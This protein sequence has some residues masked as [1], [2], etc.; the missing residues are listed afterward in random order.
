MWTADSR[1]QGFEGVSRHDLGMGELDDKI[2]RLV[3][4]ACESDLGGILL[5][6]QTNFSWLSGGGSNRID[7]SREPGAG[8]LFVAANGRRFVIAND[9][10]MPRLVAEE[11]SQGSWEPIE[12]PWTE[13]QARPDTVVRLAQRA[14][15]GRIGADWP[16]PAAV[17][18]DRP[19]TRARNLLTQPEAERYVRLG[20]D[21][22]RVLGEV[23]R[24]LEPGEDERSI[25]A[26]ADA[27]MA[28]V[29]ARAVV[30]L[31]AADDRIARFRHPV[32]GGL[33][34]QRLVMVVVGARRHGLTVSLSRIVS[35]GRV[36]APLRS[37][38]EANARVFA[39]LLE[40]TQPGASGRDL[41]KVAQ[42]AYA[43][44]GFPGE[45]KRHHQGGATGYR[46]RE[47]IA[48]PASEEKV[49]A[50]QA[51]AWNPSIT[52]TKVEETALLDES[53][54]QLITASPDWPAHPI[55]VRGVTMAAPAVLEL[56]R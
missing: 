48:H 5:T 9:I 22:G 19:I 11:L 35:S 47:W 56:G 53:G 23:C 20:A 28:T 50:R 27:A 32:A 2:E 40:T 51:F 34:W 43:A 31:V 54:L 21:A 30:T 44:A 25:A 24:T 16:L 12:Y 37:L 15:G 42:D 45:E 6:T 26:R 52:G 7:G 17:A 33:R 18:I 1:F 39:Q 29:G 38:T 10:E 3:K 4:L 13:E 41:F 46:T 49:E 36:P 8:N 55:S 14:A